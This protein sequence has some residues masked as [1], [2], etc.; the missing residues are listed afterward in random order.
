MKQ[1]LEAGWRKWKALSDRVANVQSRILLSVF[2]FTLMAP[3]GMWQAWL[4]DR[5]ALRRA[6]GPSAWVARST[7]DRTL[8]DARRQY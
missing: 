8:D 6:D 1:N 4:A 2:Y 5:L 7:G 3:F